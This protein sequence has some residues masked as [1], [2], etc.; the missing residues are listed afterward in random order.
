MTPDL[1]TVYDAAM[2]LPLQ[3][4]RLLITKLSLSDSSA[5]PRVAG[6]VEKHFGTFSSGDPDSANNEKIDADLAASYLDP[7]KPEN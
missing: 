2:K 6:A 7:H 3:E 1:N 5:R 4:R